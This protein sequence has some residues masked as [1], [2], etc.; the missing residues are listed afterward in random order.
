MMSHRLRSCMALGTLLCPIFCSEV[1]MA[2]NG[3]PV[4][5]NSLVGTPSANY[6]V[7]SPSLAFDHYGVPSVSWSTVH[8]FGGSNTVYRSKTSG[9][10]F[11][12]HRVVEQGTGVGLLTS[13]S[14]DRSEKPTVAWINGGGDVKTQFNDVTTQTLLGVAANITRPAISISHDLTGT[15]RGAFSAQSAATVYDINGANGA[16]TTSLLGTLNNVVDIHDLRFTTDYTGRRHAIAR[17]SLATNTEGVVVASEPLGGGAWTSTV[18]ATA[19][20]VNGVAIAISPSDG[21]PALAYTTYNSGNNTSKLFYA[22]PTGSILQTTEVQSSTTAVFEDI[23]LAFDYSDGLPAIAYERKVLSPF[24]QQI[25]FAYLNASSIWQTS[26][27]DGTASLDSP[28][29]FHRRPSL[30]FDDYGTSWPAISYIDADGSLT[31]AFDPPGQ[32]PEPAAVLLACIGLICL[33]RRRRG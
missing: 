2:V 5:V 27:V 23:D 9:L 19:D 24:A 18:L 1:A 21:K 3:T 16:H 25:Q 17:A 8:A 11:W 7:S 31:V 33:P 6:H 26:L 32:A 13:L 12:S 4:W 10:G 22:K 14:F 29:G 15:L 20:D 28:L 30:A